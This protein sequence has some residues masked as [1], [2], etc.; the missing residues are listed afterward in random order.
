[1]SNFKTLITGLVAVVVA[2]CGT[3]GNYGPP[4]RTD[5]VVE[6]WE[7]GNERSH[8]TFSG[9]EVYPSRCVTLANMIE[10]HEECYLLQRVSRGKGWRSIDRLICEGAGWWDTGRHGEQQHGEDD[11]AYVNWGGWDRVSPDRK[12]K[13]VVSHAA[14]AEEDFSYFRGDSWEWHAAPGERLC[15]GSH[16]EVLIHVGRNMDTTYFQ[17]KEDVATFRVSVTNPM[18]PEHL[19]KYILTVMGVFGRDKGYKYGTIDRSDENVS[20]G[21][22]Q[23][24]VTTTT[25]GDTKTYETPSIRVS[26]PTGTG[27]VVSTTIP[28]GGATFGN[29]ETTTKTTTSGGKRTIERTHTITYYR[30]AP[31]HGDYFDIEILLKSLGT[32]GAEVKAR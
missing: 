3:T 10:R 32:E 30:T 11:T 23:T 16:P 7:V 17:T 25:T 20:R 31:A 24:T 21:P 6:V 1:M 18:F 28:G 22:V 4:T 19:D 9:G 2:G 8:F 13:I 5:A 27:G 12:V 14:G 15:K 29:S 26:S